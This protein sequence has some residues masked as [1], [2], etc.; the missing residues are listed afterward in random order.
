MDSAGTETLSTMC[1][2]HE[3]PRLTRISFFEFKLTFPPVSMNGTCFYMIVATIVR[4]GQ[5]SIL[6]SAPKAAG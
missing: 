1:D 5:S 3:Q 4:V 2:R 6:T